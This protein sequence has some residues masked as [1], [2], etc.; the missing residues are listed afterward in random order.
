MIFLFTAENFIDTRTYNQIFIGLIILLY[1]FYFIFFIFFI[2]KKNK[3]DEID[4]INKKNEQDKI[5][6]KNIELFIKYHGTLPDSIL[7]KF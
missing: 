3:K 6:K 1:L 5:D 2:I 4:E 7:N